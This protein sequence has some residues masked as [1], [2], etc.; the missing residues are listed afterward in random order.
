MGLDIRWRKVV[1]KGFK[2]TSINMFKEVKEAML[3]K[4][5]GMGSLGSSVG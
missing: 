1:G 4:I 3:K 2:E 5:K